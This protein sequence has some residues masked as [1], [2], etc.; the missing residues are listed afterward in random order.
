MLPTSMPHYQ[1]LQQALVRYRVLAA[2]ASLT[3]LPPLP[4]RAVRVG[5]DY[6]G[7]DA[8]RRLLQATGDMPPPQQTRQPTVLD[9][10]LA[11]ALRNFQ[12][13]H[14]LLDDGVLGPAAWRALTTPLSQRVQQIE[15]TLQ[16]WEQLPANPGTRTLFI[17]IPQFRLIGLHSAED[18]ESQML[19][20]DVVVGRNERSLR[21]PTMITELTDVVFHPY[22]EVPASITR[23]E[24]LPLIRSNPLYLQA[25][26]MEIVAAN[27][28]LLAADAEGLA[29]LASGRARIR[30]RPGKDNALGRV[31]FI[32]TDDMAI[33][34][35]DT[36]AT[37]LFAQPRRAFSH[38]CI[39]VADPAALAQF[40]LQDDPAWPLERIQATMD[41]EETLRVKLPEPI[42][43]Y[44]VYGTALALENGEVRFF[45]DVYGLDAPSQ[46]VQARTRPVSRC[47]KSE[48]A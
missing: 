39:R 32:L 26:H 8:L 5:E 42:R 19:R 23:R 46:P 4:S 33:Y 13:R 17:N 9:A 22:W 40:A 10:P 27:G 11:D 38:G 28:S 21:T 41:G 1:L 44:V 30:Q 2:D 14:G 29:A 16:R 24:L 37:A 25:H 6:V 20:M 34:L 36:P 12:R 15:R 3:Q 18:T 7:S 48:L 43:V 45:N 31:K 47:T 35:H